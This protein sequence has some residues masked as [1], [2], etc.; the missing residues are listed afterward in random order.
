MYNLTNF[1]DFYFF[2]ISLRFIP[3]Q[4]YHV[5]FMNQKNDIEAISGK[6]YEY[7]EEPPIRGAK[8]AISVRYIDFI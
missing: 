1:N 8:I 6:S 5:Y 4:Y 3:I 2:A 7:Q